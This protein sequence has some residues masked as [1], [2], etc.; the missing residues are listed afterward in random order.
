MSNPSDRLYTAEHEW[1]RIDGDVAVEIKP[2][3]QSAE[4]ITIKERGITTE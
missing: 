4:I 3:T 2:G 1:V